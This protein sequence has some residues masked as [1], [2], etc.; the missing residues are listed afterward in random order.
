MILGA[1]RDDLDN[2]A[3]QKKIARSYLSSKRIFV[4]AIT[5]GII[6]LFIWRFLGSSETGPL[7][8]GELE[9]KYPAPGLLVRKETVIDAPVD[10]QLT[11]LVEEGERV[12]SG[13]AIAQIEVSEHFSATDSKT[14]FVVIRSPESGVVMTVDGYEDILDFGS[15]DI[16]KIS[17]ST[18]SALDDRA[19]KPTRLVKG[20]PAVKIIDSLAP[21]MIYLEVPGTFSK[22]RIAKGK[23]I[24]FIWDKEYYGGVIIDSVVGQPSSYVLL[25]VGSYPESFY[26]NRRIKLDLSGERISGFI[27]ETDSL[28]EKNGQ[29]GIYIAKKYKHKWVQVKVEGRVKDQAA[30]TGKELVAG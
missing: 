8:I 15:K 7:I 23:V 9:E 30:I 19:N 25:K 14:G 16:L 3:H 4:L 21:L 5:I 22:D 13:E 12:R 28:V 26:K 29:T 24:S 20:Q 18:L 2:Q 27:V 10:G 11:L 17:K 6:F 1:G